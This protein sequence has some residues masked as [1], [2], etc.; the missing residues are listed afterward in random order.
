M[1][2]VDICDQ[3]NRH[4]LV[5]EQGINKT[6]GHPNFRELGLLCTVFSKVWSASF[7]LAPAHVTQASLSLAQ[8]IQIHLLLAKSKDV[9]RKLKNV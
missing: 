9:I 6:R 4:M 2:Y 3:H 8:G 1:T 5:Q 7:Q